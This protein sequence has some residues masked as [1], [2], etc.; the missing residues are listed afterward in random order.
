MNLSHTM[1]ASHTFFTQYTFWRGR[2]F[3]IPDTLAPFITITFGANRQTK[4]IVIGALMSTF[5]LRCIRLC[6]MQD[7]VISCLNL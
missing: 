3:E 2:A 1:Y 6:V 5:G 7:M 4:D